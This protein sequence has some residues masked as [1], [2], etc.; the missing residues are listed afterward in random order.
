MDPILST[1]LILIL[2]VI[3]FVSNKVPIAITAIAVTL[4]LYFT[5][6]LTLPEALAG[7]GNP[8]V[9]YIAALFVVSEALDSTGVTAWAG[10][11]VIAR[12]GTSRTSLIIV[13]GLL[14]A[15]VTALISIN[16]AVATLLPLVVVVAA[17]SHLMPS[18]LL[19]P[20]A[21]TASAGSM[22]LLT[23]TPVN[24]LVSDMADQ[25]G[26]GA[27]GFFE[28][29]LVGIPLL[30]FT[31]LII[32]VLGPRLLPI[33]KV[34]IMPKDLLRHVRLLRNQYD[35]SLDTG[36]LFGPSNGVTEV[37]VPPRSNL[38]GLKVEPGMTTPTK[39]L[40]VLGARRGDDVMRGQEV[41]LQAG[42]ALLL[43]G[44]WDELTQ[45]VADRNV[46]AVD[47]PQ[48]LRRSVPLGQGAARAIIILGAMIVLMASGLMEPAV[49]AILGAVAMVL[50]RTVSITQAFQSISW[51]TVVLVAGMLP[52]STAFIQTG[53]AELV[54]SSVI[55]LV[56]GASP[57]LALL[58]LCVVTVILGQL[59]SNVATV[60]IVAPI[61]ISLAGSM[62]VSILPFLMGIAV[63]GAAS[64]LTP[65]ATPANIMVMKPGG[66]RFG[67]YW[68]LGLPL[69]ILFLLVAVFYVPLIWP[70]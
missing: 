67:D 47:A 27:F 39:D 56:G 33:R 16:G 49:A 69:A 38:I 14:V 7:F 41:T 29:A 24:I 65:I 12:A 23:G 54:A 2:A 66:Y 52:L 62:G 6:V 9:L 45:Q 25:Y 58:V 64:F 36:A 28:F 20:L 68:R 21:F 3:A 53:A 15:V 10:Q 32:L 46:L 13:I 26:P 1:F 37:V 70:F 63:A 48:T 18:Q 50:S 31:I 35:L 57:T 42:D 40:V 59:I 11:K 22:L 5:G 51:T 8:T 43:Q 4:A 34:D 55:E 60:M 44:S 61:G 30:V 17:K 19:L